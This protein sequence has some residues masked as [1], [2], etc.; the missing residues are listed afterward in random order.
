MNYKVFILSILTFVLCASG[1]ETH[2]QNV[3]ADDE[4]PAGDILP[5]R[6]LYGKP[7]K[8]DPGEVA[9]YF[10]NE[11]GR[12][13]VRI[14]GSEKPLEIFGQLRAKPS[15]ILKDVDIVENA[16][17][18]IRQPAPWI[19]QFDARMDPQSEEFSV[20]VAGDTKTLRVDLTIDGEPSPLTVRI[21][22]RKERPRALPAD[23]AFTGAR[24][25]WI[26][27]FGFE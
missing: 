21:G 11:G 24:A 25:S 13:H 7:E 5:Y 12:L 23:L 15:G 1:S 26:E 8:I 19:L 20:V 3:P 4:R 27:R 10:W 14:S 17:V 2:G 16:N 18:R 6:L 22:E 9:C